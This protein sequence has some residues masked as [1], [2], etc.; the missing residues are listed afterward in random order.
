MSRQRTTILVAT[1]ASIASMVGGASAAVGSTDQAD[2]KHGACGVL[3]DDFQYDSA[4]DPALADHGWNARS[5]MGGPGV[6]GT[7]WPAS[8]VSFVST[9]GQQ[10]A[11]L[12]ATTDGTTAGTTNAELR[13]TTMNL[14]NGTYATRVRYADRPVTG[15][16]GDHINE[17]AFA[18]G[19][20]KFDYDPI[21]SELDFTEYL[22][23]GGWGEAGPVNFQTSWHTFRE[24]PWDARTAESRQDRS[25]DGWHTYVTQVGNGHARYYI[26][27]KLT[28]DHTVDQDGNTVLPR[29][30]MSM[31]WNLWFIDLDGHQGTSTSEYHE[32]VDWAY[33][34]KNETVSP[35]QADG[36][37]QK[38]RKH[39]TTY[40]DSLSNAGSCENYQPPEHT[41]ARG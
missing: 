40:Q 38:Y 33:Y 32:Q 9:G 5:E 2:G 34:A 6:P 14:R 19:P 16:D 28:A 22:P 21:Y 36:R 30:D 39:G 8:N 4:T 17:T 23:N 1:A 11:Q 41:E 10:V 29:Q 13:R 24:D 25:L 18:I 15:T 37:V 12:R 7:A 3:F 27:G 31:N 20:T 26:D 35:T